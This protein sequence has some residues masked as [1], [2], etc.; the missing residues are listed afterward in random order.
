MYTNAGNSS[1]L[2][3]LNTQLNYDTTNCMNF[4]NIWSSHNPNLT[5]WIEKACK[6]SFQSSENAIFEQISDAGEDPNE[7]VP[8]LSTGC[9]DYLSGVYSNLVGSREI[10]FNMVNALSKKMEILWN[11]D[12]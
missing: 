12:I 6:E 11:I 2:K 4:E 5:P 7:I 10:F 9:G 1:F 3:D 8:L